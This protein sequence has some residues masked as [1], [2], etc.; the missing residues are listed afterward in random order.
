[1]KAKILL[2]LL[3]LLVFP[4]VF[5]SAYN[6]VNEN[7]TYNLVAKSG[8][9]KIL[10]LDIT[11]TDTGKDYYLN[12]QRDTDLYNFIK[13]AIQN[14]SAQKCNEFRDRVR[15]DF[16]KVDTLSCQEIFQK[17]ENEF[18][19]TVKIYQKAQQV[20]LIDI[21]K[22][23]ITGNIPYKYKN[24][25]L[26]IGENSIEFTINDVENYIQYVIDEQ[27]EIKTRLFYEDDTIV[28]S[29]WLRVKDDTTFFGANATSYTG[30]ILS[31]FTYQAESIYPFGEYQ[32]KYGLFYSGNHYTFNDDDICQYGCSY[33]TYY[34]ENN[35]IKTFYLNISFLSDG[36]IDPNY[37]EYNISLNNGI[38]TQQAEQI[39]DFAYLEFEDA[40]IVFYENFDYGSTR[41]N[42][43]DGIQGNLSATPTIN[44]SGYIGR[45]MSY[46]DNSGDYVQYYNP[47]Q[48]NNSWT[49]SYWMVSN[50]IPVST[51][52]GFRWGDGNVNGQVRSEFLSNGN[53]QFGYFDG[54][55]SYNVIPSANITRGQWTHIAHVKD[56][57]QMVTYIN[58]VPTA[59]ETLTP[60][61]PSGVFP[62]RI[63]SNA[64]M[65]S[66][67]YDEFMV[68]DSGLGQN[69]VNEIYNLQKSRFFTNGNATLLA[70]DI[71]FL[72]NN[73]VNITF[74]AQNY[75][76]TNFTIKAGSW[77]L[78]NGY[79]E[80]GSIIS[81]LVGSWHLDGN[82]SDLSGNNFA[83]TGQNAPSSSSFSVFNQSYLLDGVN[84]YFSH[85]ADI[86]TTNFTFAGW[87]YPTAIGT[88]VMFYM[89]N[90]TNSFYN[91][92]GDTTNLLEITTGIVSNQWTFSYQDGNDILDLTGGTANVNQWTH[93]ATSIDQQGLMKLY[94]NG[95]LTDSLD[96]SIYSFDG[97]QATV[98]YIGTPGYLASNRYFQG[99]V[100]D[101]FVWN[102]TLSDDQIKR[103]YTSGLNNWQ[104][105]TS[106]NVTGINAT[107]FRGN[108][109]INN[110]SRYV[111]P[112][113]EMQSE[114]GYYSPLIHSNADIVPFLANIT[115]PT[116]PVDTFPKYGSTINIPTSPTAYGNPKTYLFTQYWSTLGNL[117]TIGF[118]FA[119]V[120]YTQESKSMSGNGTY[121]FYIYNLSV[122]N[123][124]YYHWANNT[125]GE[126]NET[127]QFVYQVVKATPSL[128]ITFSPSSTVNNGTETTVTGTNCPSQLN[129]TLYRNGDIVSNPDV[130][131]L[132]AGTYT[133][134]YNTTGNA[135][136]TSAQQTETLTV[137]DSGAVTTGTGK[138]LAIV[139]AFLGVVAFLFVVGYHLYERKDN[140][141]HKKI[142]LILN[143]K[144]LS[145]FAHLGAS[146]VLVA[147]FGF[148]MVIS[149]GELY[150]SII[151]NFFIAFVWC[152]IGFNILY[153]IVYLIYLIRESY[154]DKN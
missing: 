44:T 145:V 50:N 34:T 5:A 36:N 9:E 7:P 118:E 14:P 149:E 33:H 41:Y 69:S 85:S 151:S 152:V 21:T 45:G 3:L 58:G 26:K 73:T 49:V 100:E 25:L 88:D 13:D 28:N 51:R 43:V 31:N 86:D 84:Q 48:M 27:A 91:G 117:D 24:K 38:Y 108:A 89:S 93:I 121:Q 137:R 56:A 138:E 150:E 95:I 82:L 124:T 67:T 90:G 47:M 57:N 12:I 147:L 125:L 134:V 139:V 30:G 76:D 54:G 113:I 15:S 19:Q 126:Y 79:V 4:S 42:L 75:L 65:H 135:N 98:K 105:S 18:S 59:N 46:T 107:S 115:P 103:I 6:I 142:D 77:N 68:F 53:M 140:Y 154:G 110:E 61:T 129:C 2:I 143:L 39:D 78:N 94:I 52:I 80:S 120:N 10:F 114:F 128:D 60:I 35:D 111:L 11:V 133:Y 153:I 141:L 102:G 55:Y 122:G 22:E 23:Q 101:Q 148:I 132:G 29:I 8:I 96:A 99:Y 136:Y 16:P 104:Y 144:N 130:A 106:N 32:G 37:V 63:G 1:M 112:V 40:N 131:T 20:G 62:I 70:Q 71:E 66:M 97:I 92:F 119:G 83:L 74:D 81:G 87:Y 146:W 109:S 17:L 64:A 127:N 72:G 116:P 123:Y